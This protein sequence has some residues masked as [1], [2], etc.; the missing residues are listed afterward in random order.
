MTVEELVAVYNYKP[1]PPELSNAQRQT[2]LTS[3]PSWAK[4]DGDTC[5]I[6]VG[7]YLI[8]TGYS[9]IVIGDYGAYIEIP[10]HNMVIE[11][12]KI[13]PG[14]EYR[15]LEKYKNVKYYWLCPK[16]AEH[17]KIYW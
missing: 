16:T 3:L 8:A 2:Y 9:R 12:I 5:S 11:H 1:L 17:I 15:L 6:Y 7:S 14:Q 13:T 10:P 4:I